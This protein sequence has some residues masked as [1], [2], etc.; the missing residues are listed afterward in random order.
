MPRL[1]LL[2]Q[3]AF[4]RLRATG[5]GSTVQCTWVYDRDVNVDQL[6][7]FHANL[8]AGLLGRRIERS[9]LPFGRHRWVAERRSGDM[10]LEPRR[11]RSE[12]GAW[13]E[14]RAQVAVDPEF[15]PTFHLGVQ[16]FDGGGAA[17]TLVASH[18]VVDGL[19]L[20][21]AITDA[22]NAESRKDRYPQP[23]SR[24][25]LRAVF[26]DLADA[27]NAVPAVIRAL[28]ATLTILL[29]SSS[30]PRVPPTAPGPAPH[31]PIDDE[32]TALP[33]VTLQTD[34]AA[35]EARAR[36][37][38]GSSNTLFVAFA[39]RLA[40]RMGRVLA[41][42]NSVTVVLPV[43]DR[44]ADDDRANALTSITLTVDA[45]AAAR[46]LSPVRADVKRLLTSLQ[47]NPN[48]MLAGL[49][50]IPF[51]PRWLVRRAEGVAMSAGQLPVGCSNLGSL[52][53]AVGRIDGADA[54]EVC[55]RLAEQG[56]T[57]RRIE[58]SH[59]QLFC[60]T[61]TFNGSR[62]LNVIAC[63]SGTDS[64][65]AAR[66]LACG[67]LADLQLSATTVYQGPAGW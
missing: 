25:R 22:V 1:A 39:A 36:A 7:V 26:E 64:A 60:S 41:D 8:A 31:L 15:G 23:L 47:L 45:V 6:R 16:P 11:P 65:A 30:G 46:D 3:A 56:V 33:S 19:G 29:R 12:L 40:H 51:T 61:G 48:E 2:D 52:D 38:N 9:P 62:F 42:G 55:I 27:I 49:P 34:A 57:R 5:Q 20:I 44:T 14:N 35:W 37:L 10:T 66:E 54:A 17:V 43:S 53:A 4:L 28:I 32:R 63:Q 13:V 24:N 50:L 21:T 59:G 58:Q 18:C 67:A